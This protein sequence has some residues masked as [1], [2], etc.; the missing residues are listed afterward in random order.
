MERLSDERLQE[1][2]GKPQAMPWDEVPKMAREL[3]ELRA[4]LE[5]IR[6]PSEQMLD[7]GVAADDKRTGYETCRHIYRAMIDT[8]LKGQENDA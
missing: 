5:A 8:L 4:L 1:L 7:A 3:L 2:C 6:E